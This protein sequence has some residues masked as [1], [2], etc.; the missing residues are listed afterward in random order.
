MTDKED[1]RSPCQG[2]KANFRACEREPALAG[3]TLNISR[4]ALDSDPESRGRFSDS[5]KKKSEN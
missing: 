3:A 1:A 5:R 4:E 2:R